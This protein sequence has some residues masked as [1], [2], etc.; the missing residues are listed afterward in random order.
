MSEIVLNEE[1]REVL[2]GAIEE[3][4]GSFYRGQA[5]KDL[6]KAIIERMKDEIEMPPKVFR[7]LAKTSYD[8][9]AKKQNDELTE[10][11]DLAEELGFY[12]HQAED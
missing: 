9:S 4:V 1:K 5:E 10:I 2:K 6:Q 8:D 11:L 3:M 12:S 7:K